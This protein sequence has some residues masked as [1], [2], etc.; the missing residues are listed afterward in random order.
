VRVSGSVGIALFPADAAKP[1]DLIKNADMA[2]YRAKAEG[3]NGGRFYEAAMDDALRQ[4]RQL[5][6]DLRLAIVRAELGVHYQPLADLE[7][8]RI[9]GFEALLRWTHPQLGEIGPA[10]FIP[11]AEESGLILKLGEWVLREACT[12]AARWTPPLKLSVNL[13]PVQFAQDDLAGLVEQILAETGLDPARLDLEV[14]EGLLIK[15]AERAI[16]ILQRLKALGVRISM[17][18]FGTGYSSLS[19]FRMF[20]FDKVKI[21]QSFIHDMIKNPQARAIIRSVIGL[22]RGLGMPVVAEGV[23]TTEQL[24]ALRDE[25]CDQVQGYLI[26]RPNPISHFEGVVM[27]RSLGVDVARRTSRTGQGRADAA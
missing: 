8:G 19:Y 23:E 4:R 14:T 10:T 13:S 12:E 9:I 5:D 26:S 17:D 1:E 25:G 15:D 20:P 22:G 7:S 21:D 24:D 3:R 18:D 6:N 11:L 27:D 16:G 2:L